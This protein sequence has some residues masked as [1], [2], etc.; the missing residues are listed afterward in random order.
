MSD[1]AATTSGGCE[2]RNEVDENSPNLDLDCEGLPNSHVSNAS[3]EQQGVSFSVFACALCCTLGS[4]NCKDCGTFNKPHPLPLLR[5]TGVRK[6][7]TL[8]IVNDCSKILKHTNTLH[9]KHTMNFKKK[10]IK[11]Y[12]CA[13]D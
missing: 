13:D 6:P 10:N 1:I 2:L 7:S 11:I 5:H 9:K 3:I 12:K 4:L 8:L